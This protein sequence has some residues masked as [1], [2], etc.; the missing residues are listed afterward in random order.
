MYAAPFLLGIPHATVIKI[1]PTLYSL[2]QMKL[3]IQ[4]AWKMLLY[5]KNEMSSAQPCMQWSFLFKSVLWC[6]EVEQSNLSS[7]VSDVYKIRLKLEQEHLY[8]IYK[9][10]PILF[11]Q[12]SFVLW[13]LCIDTD[14]Y[15][16]FYLWHYKAFEILE[17]CLDHV[18]FVCYQKN[19][20]L[21]L[22]P[23]CYW[24]YLSLKK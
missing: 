16:N 8:I 1:M 2:L 21:V 15:Y 22:S 19:V 12:S 20:C 24:W 10:T 18:L 5:R 9:L 13:I 23:A 4:I 14:F 3:S 17:E 7:I 11:S 6:A